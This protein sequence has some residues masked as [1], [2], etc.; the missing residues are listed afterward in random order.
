MER[1]EECRLFFSRI[2]M[3]TEGEMIAGNTGQEK[4][5]FLYPPGNSFLNFLDLSSILFSIRK[6][7]FLIT[8]LTDSHPLW[9]VQYTT[10]YCLCL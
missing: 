3:G 8:K 2:S 7:Y 9:N 1:G 4:T 5:V 6:N 10:C